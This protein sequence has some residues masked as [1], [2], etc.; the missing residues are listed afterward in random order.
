MSVASWERLTREL[1]RDPS[2]QELT[3]DQVRAMIDVILL[4]M[5][6]DRRV[7]PLEVAG[8]THLFFDLPWLQSREELVRE[9]IPKAAE[10]G[11]VAGDE[12][13]GRALARDVAERLGGDRALRERVFL[14]A[15]S[16]AAADSAVEAG[17]KQALTWVADAFGI[18]PELMAE[19]LG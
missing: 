14:M 2:M 3:D 8:F 9:H 17:E 6:A 5:H 10:R 13:K 11:A 4:T 12:A 7:S 19:A 15:A 16:L 18:S 1:V